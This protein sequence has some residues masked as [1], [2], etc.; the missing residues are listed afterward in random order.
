[1][2][3]S[4]DFVK[5]KR[6]GIDRISSTIANPI[7]LIREFRFVLVLIFHCDAPEMEVEAE[8]FGPES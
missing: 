5:Q 8:F 3:A 2:E 7:D 6:T 4:H 1:M